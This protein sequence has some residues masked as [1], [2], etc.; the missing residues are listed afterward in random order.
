MSAKSFSLS[1]TNVQPCAS[2]TA[3][4]IVSSALRG[5]PCVLPSAISRAQIERGVLVEGEHA[6]GEQRLRA[7]RTGEPG[8]ELIAA[9]S[10]RL[11]EN[12][13]ADFGDGQ[14]GDEQVLVDL[15]AHPG[16]QGLRGGLG[17]A[18]ALMMFESSSR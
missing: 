9:L 14:R 16:E 17:L 8:L 6:A 3:A 13:S 18:M 7:L 2:A 12:P 10:G 11:F 15:L 5:R 4:M 1:V